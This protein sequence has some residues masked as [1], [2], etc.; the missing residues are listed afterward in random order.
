MRAET[1]LGEPSYR[2]AKLEVDRRRAIEI[3]QKDP[4]LTFA[5]IARRLGRGPSFVARWLR[6]A[7]CVNQV[8]H[9][10][11]VV[12]ELKRHRFTAANE[13]E[14]Q[15]GVARVLDAMGLK[16]ERE[17]RLSE[18]DVVDFFVAPALGI[19]LKVGG[20]LAA[21]TRQCYRYLGHDE[22]SELLVV[23]TR[24]RLAQL[25]P[26]MRGKRLAVVSLMGGLQ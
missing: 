17:V 7:G 15:V 6:E 21:V 11:A 5:E 23:T 10:E 19:E 16:Y 8:S 2:Q 13:K 3:Y 12:A 1:G 24:S 25:P 26:Q 14:L 4:H 22:L 20:G 18:H 9:I